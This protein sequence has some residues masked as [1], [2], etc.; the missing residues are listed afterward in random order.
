M[1]ISCRLFLLLFLTDL[2][3]T[4]PIRSYAIRTLAC[5]TKKTRKMLSRSVMPTEQ[6]GEDSRCIL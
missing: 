6:S 3:L 2:H 5:V 1:G 4:Y